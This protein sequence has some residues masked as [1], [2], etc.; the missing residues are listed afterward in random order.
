MRSLSFPSRSQLVAAQDVVGALDRCL[1]GTWLLAGSLGYRPYLPAGE[2]S[3]RLSDIDVVLDPYEDRIPV[4]RMVRS[5]V[6]RDFTVKHVRP[7]NAGRYFGMV[8][9]ATGLW[10]DIYT[11][12]HPV[13][14]TW[15]ALGERKIRTQIPEETFFALVKDL[16]LRDRDRRT[17]RPK[18]VASAKLLW[19][20]VDRRL[21]FQLMDRYVDEYSDLV[22]RGIAIGASG[23]VVDCAINVPTRAPRT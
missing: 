21:V 9:R 1:A 17:V 10:V 14:S 13:L 2:R 7:M 23:D 8:H 22:P 16:L 4:H 20:H 19:R 18:W 12:P 15:L 3:A 11:A 5:D 6:D